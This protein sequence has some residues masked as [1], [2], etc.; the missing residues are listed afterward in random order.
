MWLSINTGALFVKA[1]ASEECARVRF[2]FH[3]QCV[4]TAHIHV[5]CH[6]MAERLQHTCF[7]SFLSEW[8]LYIHV[9][10][11]P[12]ATLFQGWHA[13]P[14]YGTCII[15][16]RASNSLSNCADRLHIPNTLAPS[17]NKVRVFVYR[18]AHATRTT[19]PNASVVYANFAGRTHRYI[20]HLYL[21][22]CLDERPAFR[23]IYPSDACAFSLGA[24][25]HSERLT[26]AYM[27]ITQLKLRRL[28]ACSE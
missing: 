18:H 27:F 12:P 1:Q 5:S 25:V 21:L 20:I 17:S 3:T 24:G 15:Y 4:Q 13:A 7:M 26:P 9:S 6:G 14:T 10:A 23:S 22:R 28:P 11:T 16:L 2:R 19:M 8:L